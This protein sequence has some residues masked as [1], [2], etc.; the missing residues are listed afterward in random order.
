MKEIKIIF[1]D[2]DGTLV[3]MNKKQISEKTLE[4]VRRLR[5]KNVILCIATGRTPVTLPAFKDMFDVLVTFNGSYCFN[6]QETIFSNPLDAEDVQTIIKNAASIHRPVSIATKDCVAANGRDKD[7][8][9]YYSFANLEVDVN[10][11]FEAISQEEVYQI[12]MGGREDE[13]AQILDGVHGAKITAW[14]DRSVDIIPSNGGK[15][16]GIEKVLE[17]YHLSKEEAAAFGDGNNDIEMLQTVGLGVAMANA[18]ADLKAIADDECG[19]V[20]EDGIYYYCLEH[21]WI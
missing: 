17:Y 2:I 3:D 8:V 7:L 19:S 9:E 11:N 16:R 12:M 13:Y 4:T 21:G 15:G 18:S 1:F 6:K 20:G 14:W 5:E 10:E